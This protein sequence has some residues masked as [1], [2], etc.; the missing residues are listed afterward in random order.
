MSRGANG[1][2]SNSG[3]IGTTWGSSMERGTRRAHAEGPGRHPEWRFPTRD[4]RVPTS[5]LR[6]GCRDRRS[7]AASCREVA[8][9]GHPERLAGG[10]EIVEDLVGQ[11][12][13]EHA[14]IAKFEQVILEGLELDA[15]RV[16]YV[17]DPDLTEVR[18]PCLGA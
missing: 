11:R 18:E 6:I 1:W 10:D 15:G 4:Q 3:P 12:F 2:R 5:V 16:R 9:H 13:V 17:R 8:D 7:Y 14:L